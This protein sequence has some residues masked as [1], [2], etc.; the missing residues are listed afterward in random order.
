[1]ATGTLYTYPENFRAYKALIAAKYSGAKVTV[2]PDFKL[3][4]SNTT[5]EFLDKFP[6]GKVPAFESSNGDCVFESNAIAQYVGN[7]KLQGSNTRDQALIQQ[8][9]NFGDNEV[10]PASCTWVF[11]TLG[12]TPFNKQEGE[13][14]KEQMKNAMTVLNNYMRTR[15]YLVGERI[16][17]ADI[18][19]ACNLMLAYQN[20]MDPSFRDSFGNVNRWFNTLV[21][22]PQFKAVIGTFTLCSKMKEADGKKYAEL[23]GAGGKKE[24]KSKKEQ[25]KKEKKKE[26]EE[27]ELPQLPRE[28]KDPWAD[29]PQ[30]AFNYDEYKREYSNKDTLKE[31]LPYFWKNF[32]PENMSIWHCDYNYR[33]DLT[34]VFMTSNLIRGFFQRIDK[35]RKNAF[36][37]MCIL[38][39]DD[40]HNISGVWFWRGSG[41]A[42]ELCDD[43]KVDYESYTW[44]KLDPKDEKT[45]KLV[46]DYFDMAAVVDGKKCLQGSIYK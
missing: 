36:G 44:K 18:S 1:M 27:E 15:T 5:K 14:A 38:G 41:L 10:Y 25:P 21:N 11:P 3:G 16:S 42:F 17:Q 34:K 7:A 4:V 43:W 46:Q 28:K 6:L 45:K 2:S 35:M 8:W 23:H 20:V 13:K 31:A 24:G 39:E 32:E 12:I 30:G 9:I 19:L 22:Q 33:K 40:D 37:S 29:C 26:V